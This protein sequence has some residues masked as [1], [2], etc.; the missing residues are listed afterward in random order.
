MNTLIKFA[1]LIIIAEEGFSSSEYYCSQ[2]Y[3][4]TGFGRKVSNTKYLPLSDNKVTKSS[5]ILFVKS[6]ISEIIPQLSKKFPKA[7]TNCNDAQKAILI[8][9][10]YQL[11]LNGVSA[12]TKM[13]K[14]LDIK[15]WTLAYKEMLNSKWARQTP[16]RANRHAKQILTGNVDVY[17]LTN[18]EFK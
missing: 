11:G 5:E 2:G 1:E 10:T 15:D 3:V 13:W 6:K 4:T 16:N 18:G 14:A 8:S 7:W 9:M 17:Y 12:F